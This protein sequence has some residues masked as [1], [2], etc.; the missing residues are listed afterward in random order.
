MLYFFVND[1]SNESFH[2]ARLQCWMEHKNVLYTDTGKKASS[3]TRVEE[4]RLFYSRKPEYQTKEF[5]IDFGKNGCRGHNARSA[6]DLIKHFKEG[7]DF[8]GNNYNHVSAVEYESYRNWVFDIY[9]K[10]MCLDIQDLSK[11]LATSILQ[12]SKIIN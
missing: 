1:N 9:Q 8:F 7:E 11:Q 2:D 3:F 4:I 5:K 12:Q 10:E 6:K